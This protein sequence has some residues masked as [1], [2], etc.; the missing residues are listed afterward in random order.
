ML[1]KNT[2]KNKNGAPDSI[3]VFNYKNKN[4]TLFNIKDFVIND[5]SVIE[6][7][8]TSLLYRGIRIC[9]SWQN[10]VGL[11]NPTIRVFI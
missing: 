4:T 10:G 11:N 6:L 1:N 9:F 2:T 7:K 3:V 5:G 8:E